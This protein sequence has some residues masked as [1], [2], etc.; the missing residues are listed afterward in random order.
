MWSFRA[1]SS[2]RLGLVALLVVAG[3]PPVAAAVLDVTLCTDT[4]PGGAPG[5]LRQALAATVSGDTIRLPPCTI[6]LQGGPTEDDLHGDLDVE[7]KVL[8]LRGAGRGRTIL[9]AGGEHRVL[10]VRAGAVVSV[11][12]VT[13]R[14]GR[15]LNGG[16]IQVDVGGTLEL[17]DSEVLDNVGTNSGG[18]I[19]NLGLLTVRRSTVSGN[20]TDGAGGG[21]HSSK[22]VTS[23]IDS[24]LTDNEA[25][26]GGGAASF[27]AGELRVEQS[28]V[29]GN[30]ATGPLGGGGVRADGRVTVLWSTVTGNTALAGPGGGLLVVDPAPVV[31]GSSIVAQNA[32][33][34]CSGTPAPTSLGHNVQ[35]DGSCQL[36]HPTDIASPDPGLGPLAP[37][38][39]PTATHALLPDSPALDAGGQTGC[40]GADQRGVSRPQG[41]GPGRCDAGAV[42][43]RVPTGARGAAS[44]KPIDPR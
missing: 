10:D 2:A 31:V 40:P 21:I 11:T 37:N 18:G 15:D 19:L 20:R 35:G 5:E 12:D 39:G 30:R 28:T 38:G 22:A 36:G 23:I 29:S 33:D 4:L 24:T 9:R 7:G 1:R 41:A 3:G 27:V 34:D 16:G 32:P 43:R 44:A 13:V 17:V 8:A 42:E 6:T 25:A 14:D 26:T